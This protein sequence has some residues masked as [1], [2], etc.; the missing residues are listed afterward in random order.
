MRRRTGY[1]LRCVLVSTD[2]VGTKPFPGPHHRPG[3][4]PPRRPPPSGWWAPRARRGPGSSRSSA[5]SGT[6]Q[7]DPINVVARNPQ[8]VLWSRIGRYDPALLEGLLAKRE[9]FETVSSSSRPA[10]SR[11]TR[12]RCAPTGSRQ[13]GAAGPEEAASR[14]R[15][16]HLAASRGEILA[17]NPMLRRRVLAR[18]RREG[19]LP[20]TAF[21]G[22]AVVSWTTARGIRANVTWMLAILQRRGEVVVAGRRRG[23]KLWAVADGWLPESRP[24]S[25]RALGARSHAAGA[26]R[27]G[28]RYAQ[29]VAFHYVPSN[30]MSASA[31]STRSCARARPCHWRSSM[32]L[33]GPL[34]RAGSGL[35]PR[36]LG[37]PH[38]AALA[39]RQPGSSDRARTEQLFG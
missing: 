29:A 39:L 33:E 28:R 32:R 7:L 18:L 20:L 35:A 19:P 13:P 1:V 14:R 23:H 5:T 26:P 10:T 21:E 38:D 27:P 30:V 8:L 6:F 2:A 3:R 31:P 11:C 12:R 34:V 22:R 15:R 37:R 24:L 25:G 17:L 16:R 4:A 36:R 9:L